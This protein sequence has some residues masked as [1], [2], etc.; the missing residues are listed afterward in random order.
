MHKCNLS[1]MQTIAYWFVMQISIPGLT[2]SAVHTWPVDH[3]KGIAFAG[4][5]R[6][7]VGSSPA[8]KNCWPK[9]HSFCRTTLTCTVLEES[10]NSETKQKKEIRTSDAKARLLV[11]SAGESGV[12]ASACTCENAT[13]SNPAFNY[14]RK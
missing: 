13:S 12:S 14:K 6:P 1:K 7:N 8:M 10:D 3:S 5:H 2:S 9:M 11:V 4:S